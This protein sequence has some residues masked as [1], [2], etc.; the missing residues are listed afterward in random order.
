[1]SSTSGRPVSLTPTAAS[2]PGIEAGAVAPP[3]L[4]NAAASSLTAAWEAA[5]SVEVMTTAARSSSSPAPLAKIPALPIQ[6]ANSCL[7]WAL[8]AP[9]ISSGAI[10]PVNS[11]SRPNPVAGAVGPELPTLLPSET[12]P[13]M[14]WA[15]L[16]RVA[17]T[18]PSPIASHDSPDSSSSAWALSGSADSS[19][20]LCGLASGASV[21]ASSAS[22]V[23]AG[24]SEM[25]AS[26]V[27]ARTWS[28]PE[29]P[30][31]PAAWL[32]AALV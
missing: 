30:S 20:S 1:M 13:W 4:R 24:T 22:E 17:P 5:G 26:W 29:S 16:L 7:A 25:F 10:S 3:A 2:V 8:S 14:S 6:L 31:P 21:S 18:W 19:P 15:S 11:E 28:T 9:S 23:A 27:P 32:A 12:S